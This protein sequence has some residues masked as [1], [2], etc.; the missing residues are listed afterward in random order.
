MRLLVHSNDKL[1]KAILSESARWKF[2]DNLSYLPTSGLNSTKMTVDEKQGLK[3]FSCKL[4][5]TN[6]KYAKDLHKVSRDMFG[7][8]WYIKSRVKGQAFGTITRLQPGLVVK[9]TDFQ[10]KNWGRVFSS[11]W[12]VLLYCPLWPRSFFLQGCRVCWRQKRDIAL[13]QLWG[14]KELGLSES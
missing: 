5:R 2:Q 14:P 13:W 1:E 6:K 7:L 10:H 8:I 4:P 3:C 9:G 12:E 11:S